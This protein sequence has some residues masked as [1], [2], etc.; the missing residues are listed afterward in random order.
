VSSLDFFLKRIIQAD[1]ISAVSHF[2]YF[3]GGGGGF[4]GILFTTAFTLPPGVPLFFAVGGF[5]GT[6]GLLLLG[7]IFLLLKNCFLTFFFHFM[8][9]FLI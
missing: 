4:G 8:S 5:C 2:F 9:P 7:I 6:L 1:L 3:F